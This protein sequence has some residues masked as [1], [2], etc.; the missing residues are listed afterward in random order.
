[1]KSMFGVNVLDVHVFLSFHC[2]SVFI[3]LV[4]VAES[5][6]SSCDTVLM[7]MSDRV[8]S[9]AGGTNFVSTV[10]SDTFKIELYFEPVPRP[11]SL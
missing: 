4:S 2:L 10:T 1:M 9:A 5:S 7:F 6:S 11:S 8:L 3:I